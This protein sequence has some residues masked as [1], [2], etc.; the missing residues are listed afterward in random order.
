MMERMT[1]KADERNRF[2]TPD[3]RRDSMTRS[4][5]LSNSV[6]RNSVNPED[7]IQSFFKRDPVKNSLFSLKNIRRT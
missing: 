2:S 4:Q 1:L 5:F 7:V 6:N 3:R